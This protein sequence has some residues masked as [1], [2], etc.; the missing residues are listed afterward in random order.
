MNNGIVNN[1]YEVFRT[2]SSGGGS[3][4]SVKNCRR[5]NSSNYYTIQLFKHKPYIP[6]I[7]DHPTAKLLGILES[8]QHLDLTHVVRVLEVQA[9]GADYL[10]K[11]GKAPVDVGYAV[12]EE[13]RHGSVLD[14]V[15]AKEIP[16][17]VCRYF[18]R[19]II[20]GI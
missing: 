15:M 5:L 19:Q 14:L 18:F 4:S 20:E 17:P 1:R 11:H 7:G 2:I 6:N 3:L 13:C 16:E 9:S 8:L 10:R 12:M